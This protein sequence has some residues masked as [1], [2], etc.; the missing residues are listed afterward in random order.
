M[1]HLLLIRALFPPHSLDD[2]DLF[3]GPPIMDVGVVCRSLAEEVPEG[4]HIVEKSV[5]NRRDANLNP[6]KGLESFYL[7]YKGGRAPDWHLHDHSTCAPIVDIVVVDFERGERC[8]TG[9]VPILETIGGE[10]A[11]LSKRSTGNRMYASLVCVCSR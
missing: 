8:P 5:S 7:C 6:G 4:Y 10:H 2:I 3:V 11:P 1:F 9:Y